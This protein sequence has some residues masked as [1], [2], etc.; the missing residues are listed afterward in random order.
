M[1]DNNLLFKA[2]D[3]KNLDRKTWRQSKF[4]RFFSS[5][6][7]PLG[8]ISPF[9]IR[10]KIQLQKIWKHGRQRDK[11]ISGDNGN[12]IRDWVQETE[13]LVTVVVNRLVSGRA[14]GDTM[15]LHVFCDASLEATAAVTYIKT[16]RN[17]EIRTRFLTGKTSVAPLLQTTFTRLELQAALNSARLKKTIKALMDFKFDKI[18]LKKFKLKHKMYIGIRIAEIRDLTSTN[19]WK[20]VNTKDNPADYGTR[21]RT[22]TD[23]TEK[24]PRLQGPQFVLSS[25]DNW[26][27]D[28]QHENVFLISAEQKPQG[29]QRRPINKA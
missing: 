3:R 21:G 28:E 6:C 11:A 1:E 8:I 15:E 16:T 25:S 24:P 18:F 10:A 4:L 29:T 17:Q 2:I 14:L 20:Y 22:G 12:A 13:L 19:Q 7:D 23:M 26:K 9:L 5:F 27:T